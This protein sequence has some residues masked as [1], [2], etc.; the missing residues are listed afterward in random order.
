MG[1]PAAKS[2]ALIRSRDDKDGSHDAAATA[3][4]GTLMQSFAAEK[5]RGKRLRLR[6]ELKTEDVR[7]AETLWMRVDGGAQHSLAFDNMEQRTSEGPLS[8]THDWARRE[9]VLDVAPEAESVHFG[10]YLRGS[11]RAWARNFDLTEVGADVPV[12]QRLL[13]GPTNLD[14]GRLAGEAD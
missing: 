14:F 11:G 3:G 8:G 1:V 2:P 6:A 13:P 5:F 4:F 7:G 9:V 12:T 10:F